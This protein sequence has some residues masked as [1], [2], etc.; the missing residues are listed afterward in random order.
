[1]LCLCTVQQDQVP[2]DVRDRLEREITEIALRSLGGAV[3]PVQVAWVEVAAGSGYTARQP[4]TSSIV[5]LLVPDGT[6]ATARHALMQ[7]VG[8]AWVDATGCTVHEIVVSAVDEGS[9]APAG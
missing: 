7:G 3:A 6:D 1:M 2:A 4:S 8:D 9:L 5:G